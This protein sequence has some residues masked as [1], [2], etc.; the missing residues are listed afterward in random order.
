MAACKHIVL[1]GAGKSSTAL[2]DYLKKQSVLNNWFL[3][4]ADTNLMAAHAKVGK[5]PN[6]KAVHLNIESADERQVLVKQADAVISLLPPALHYVLALDC[7][8]FGKHLLTAS[9][10]DENIKKLAADIKNKGL[11]FLCEMG[12]DPGIDHMSAMKLLHDIK[13]RQGVITSFISHCGGLVAPES[14]N[15]PWHYKISW[16]PRNVV[17]A[18]KAG[19]TF[20][21][22]GQ[23]VHISYNQLFA[24]N[25]A[26]EVPGVGPLVY[27]PNRD[28]SGYAA[29]YDVENAAT[30]I[31]TTL[32]H[33]AFCI[34]WKNI[35]DLK[36]TDEE[37]V[38]QT[39]G[40]TIAG[41]FKIHFEKNGFANWLNDMLGSRL[42]YA[43]EMMEKL[44][45]LMEAEETEA[46][47]EAAEEE[48]EDSDQFMMVNE[49]GDL[50]I[51]DVEDVKD[52]AAETVATTMQEANLSMKQLFFL[53]L[54]DEQPINRGLCSAADVLQFILE[55][56][57]AL[58]PGDKDMVV[59][60]HE[61]NYLLNGE[62]QF[63]KSW[64]VVKGSDNIHTA[65][66]KTVGLPLGI[67]AKLL[68]E[69][70]IKETGLHIPIIQGIYDPVLNELAKQGIAFQEKAGA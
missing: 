55:K 24:D 20:R 14:D 53:G 70:K 1:F 10:I 69:G 23:Q 26:V 67:A 31:R 27:Y 39:D 36:L 57:L 63:V 12:L 9:Y 18:G 28:S 22:N 37:K 44:M 13:E 11:L 33:P 62:P 21:Q 49:K 66:A 30:F 32:R 43:R 4:V 61:I 15:N 51:V 41:F 25:H 68:L 8:A 56:K 54:D 58:Q 52:K 29:L 16:N 45:E 19:A 60:M 48:E 2:I 34:G 5:H 3:T 46:G 38:Y 7:L 42:S 65:M 17:L 47:D 35:V 40:M 64:L 50:S 6:A 59:M